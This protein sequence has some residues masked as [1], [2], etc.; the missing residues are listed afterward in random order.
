MRYSMFG[1]I[2]IATLATPELARA[3]QQD[4][5]GGYGATCSARAD[6][7]EW[8]RCVR[9]VCVDVEALKSSR[10]NDP[11][12]N[13]GTH[14][15]LGGALGASLPTIWGSAGEGF[16]F[17]MR[18]GA[19]LNGHV[20]FELEVEPGTVVNTT[21]SVIR[22]FDVVATAGYLIPMSS[23]VSWIMRVGGG[24]GALFGYDASNAGSA[25]AFGQVR[26]DV[27]GVA[28]RTSKHVLF[29]FNAPSFRINFVQTP[30]TCCGNNAMFMWVTNVAFNYIF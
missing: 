4:E 5:R 2:A 21:S 6:C 15:L 29:E 17:G 24:G 3:Q 7:G 1:A 12:A 26:L 10:W 9:N 20:Q 11:T 23:M 16:E 25:L 13:E 28:I 19:L 18:F 27:V 14:F 8:L 30:A 22:M